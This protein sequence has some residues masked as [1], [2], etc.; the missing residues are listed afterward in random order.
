MINQNR[1][2]EEKK[3][4]AFVITKVSKNHSRYHIVFSWIFK[5]CQIFKRDNPMF[6]S[7]RYPD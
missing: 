6:L 2:L 5:T 7:M 1:R 3:C 4:A